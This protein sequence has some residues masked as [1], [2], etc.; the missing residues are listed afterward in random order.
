MKE[1]EALEKGIEL[2]K[3]QEE[4]KKLAKLVVLKDENDFS[5][6]TRFAGMH[7][8]MLGKEILVSIVVLDEA[9]EVIEEKYVTRPPRFPYIPGYQ[10][11]RELPAMLAAFDKLEEVP[12]VIFIESTGIAHARG[13]GLASHFG[14]TVG[15]PTIGITKDIFEGEKKDKDVIMNKKVVASLLETKKGSNPIYVSPGHMLTLKTALELTKRCIKEPHKMPEPIVQARKS[16]S[17]VQH[18]MGH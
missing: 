8:E 17:T 5:Q 3:L 16:A 18:E 15:K 2:G 12:D 4:Q 9:L 1:K 14:L 6:A 10:A 11:Y 13:L 7:I